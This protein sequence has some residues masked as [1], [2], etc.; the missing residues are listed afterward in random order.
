MWHLALGWH[1]IE[2]VQ[3]IRHIGIL[4]P[5]SI[6]TISPQLTCHSAPVCEILSKSD[7]LR[8]KKWTSCRFSRWRISAILD[9]K[10]P[11]TGSLKNP[12]T[13]SYRSS[14]KAIA[15]NCLRLRKSQFLHF[16]DRQTD[17]QPDKPMDKPIILSRCREHVNVS[18]W[19]KT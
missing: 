1:A 16:G 5:V 15:L 8:H 14:I 10:G 7:R 12:C 4:L 18:L 6:S 11:I 13:T 9:Y 17:K 19:R 3:I 2:F